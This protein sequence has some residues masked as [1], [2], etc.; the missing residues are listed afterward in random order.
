MESLECRCG[1]FFPP[2]PGL[3][4]EAVVVKQPVNL[5]ALRVELEALVARGICSLAVVLL[6]SY[7]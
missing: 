2:P 7:L 3:T 5:V 6:H 1:L 4:G